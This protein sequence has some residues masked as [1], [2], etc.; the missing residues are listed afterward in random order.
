MNRVIA[1]L[2]T[3]GIA[4]IACIAFTGSASADASAQFQFAGL[5]APDDPN[6]DGFRFSLLYGNSEKLGGFDLAGAL[7]AGSSE[8]SGAGPWFAMAHVRGDSRGCLCSFANYIEGT[9]HGA[10]LAFINIVGDAPEG[11]NIGFVNYTEGATTF[12]LSGFGIS[13]RSKVQLGFINV[14]DEIERFQIGF[15]NVAQNGFLPVFPIFNF[16]KSSQ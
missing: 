16:P 10:A 15:L 2:C 9:S 13:E 14:T 7:Y 3:I 5:R 12:D 4:C 1:S 6:V 11:V 8:F